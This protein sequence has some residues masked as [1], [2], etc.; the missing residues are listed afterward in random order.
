MKNSDQAAKLRVL[1]NQSQYKKKLTPTRL[2]HKRVLTVASGKGGVG[3]TNFTLN[4]AIA[5]NQLS[6]RVMILDADLGMANVDVLCGLTPKYNLAHVLSHVKNFH[7][8]V[9]DCFNGVKIVP[10]VSGI[11]TLSELDRSQ[12]LF[13]FQE[14]ENY[15]KTDTSELL[16]IDIGAGLSPAVLNFILAGSENIIVTTP[17]PTA[18]M[19]AYALIKTIFLKKESA[20]IKLV[21]N[22]V[23]SE[24]E[25]LQIYN[26]L[27]AIVKKFMNLHI[28][29]LGFI[30]HDKNVSVAVK[31]QVPLL[32]NTPEAPASRC[33][34]KIAQTIAMSNNVNIN[35]KTR[36][37]K[38]L[39]EKI[40]FFVKK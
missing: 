27:N 9:L 40:S 15:E 6:E 21:V 2:R 1:A 23:R 7:E 20:H 39:F 25:A 11:D 5:L 14:L 4:I 12:Q 38:G 16:L 32:L 24:R 18:L 29:Y 10:G 17:E 28:E 35:K 33:L 36:G 8:I 22:M 37:I 31:K 34:R 19:D 26:S 30:Y 13:F 3:K